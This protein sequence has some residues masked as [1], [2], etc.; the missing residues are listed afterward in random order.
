MLE[1]LRAPPAA[2]VPPHSTDSP[3]RGAV[4]VTLR[5]EGAVCAGR[6]V[7]EVLEVETADE[8][9]AHCSAAAASGLPCSFVSYWQHLRP[10]LC[11]LF[12]ACPRFEVDPARP[13]VASFVRVLRACGRRG[14]RQGM[15][16]GYDSGATCLLRRRLPLCART[17]TRSLPP[18]VPKSTCGPSARARAYALAPTILP[19]CI[20][21]H[22]LTHS[23]LLAGALD[24]ARAASWRSLPVCA[25]ASWTDAR[26]IYCAETLQAAG[27]AA[28]H[29]D[30]IELAERAFAKVCPAERLRRLAQ[31]DRA[32][33][34]ARTCCALPL[35]GKRAWRR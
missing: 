19:C 23:P 21:P 13:R 5:S 7:A 4:T 15:R 16:I 2:A 34:S 30:A 31:P 3:S 27:D 29:A 6:P 20:N 14:R 12:S 1:R 8:C 26:A 10:G 17:P 24:T 32:L 11:Q 28:A 18:L 33:I 9:A 25:K 35:F 22:A